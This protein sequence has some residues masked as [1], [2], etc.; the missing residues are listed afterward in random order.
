MANPNI[1]HAT[2]PSLTAGEVN[3]FNSVDAVNNKKA[4]LATAL[5]EV[6]D[7][8]TSYPVKAEY[9]YQA[10]AAANVV[11]SATPA[12]LVGMIIGADVASSVIEV[13]DSAT[14][15]DGAVKI[16]LTGSTLMTSC[17]G[18]VPVGAYFATG[19]ASDMTNQTDVTFIII[20][21]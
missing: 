10:A 19:I 12:I 20:K 4:T 8:I 15:G 16:E 6:N 9:V 5:D 1:Y 7:A 21:D 2:A 3:Y 14:D 13:S 17:G 18:Y 11:V